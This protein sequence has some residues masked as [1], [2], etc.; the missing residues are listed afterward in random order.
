MS[1]D[2]YLQVSADVGGAEPYVCTL[3]KANYTH[4]CNVMA[5][6]AGIYKH[7][8]RPEELPEIKTAGDLI[9]PL[10]AGILR[11]KGDPQKFIALNPANGWGSYKTF[12]PWLQEYLEAC[13]AY[14]KA[15]ISASR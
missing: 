14:P 2:L 4:N 15:T 9:E 5:E 1:L 8:W 7:V 3:W 10:R 12:L 13:M 6:A 11:M